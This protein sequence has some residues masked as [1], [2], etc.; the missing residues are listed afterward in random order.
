MFSRP[1]TK[2]RLH[3]SGDVR[4]ASPH[5]ISKAS[6]KSLIFCLVKTW[7]I[8]FAQSTE[9][10]LAQILRTNQLMAASLCLERRADSDVEFEKSD[11]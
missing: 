8:A 3:S 6:I 7:G 5:F 11:H 4:K 9:I 10:E 2:W 1:P